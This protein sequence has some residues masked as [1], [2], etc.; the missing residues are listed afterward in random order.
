MGIAR[1][2]SSPHLT[3]LN[4]ATR[5]QQPDV[6][7]LLI[8]C[9]AKLMPRAFFPKKLGFVGLCGVDVPGASTQQVSV[10]VFFRQVLSFC[11]R[12]HSIFGRRMQCGAL[13]SCRKAA[14]PAQSCFARA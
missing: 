13:L 8:I 9:D 4:E 14:G 10:K 3:P 7:Q 11:E 6:Q 5:W 12:A 2:D 1:S